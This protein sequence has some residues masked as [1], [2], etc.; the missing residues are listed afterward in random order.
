VRAAEKREG[1]PSLQR[2]KGEG[3]GAGICE[4]WRAE[5]RGEMQV[6]KEEKRGRKR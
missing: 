3:G 2:K 4:D 1:A 5:K 6:E